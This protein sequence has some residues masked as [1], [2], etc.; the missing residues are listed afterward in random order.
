MRKT[1]FLKTNVKPWKPPISPFL[2]LSS[3]WVE[4]LLSGMRPVHFLFYVGEDIEKN[5]KINFPSPSRNRFIISAPLPPSN[6]CSSTIKLLLY[7][8]RSAPL[9]PSKCSSTII[10]GDPLPSSEVLLY[11]HQGHFSAIIKKPP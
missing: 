9:I 6:Y 10:K 4:S 11:N 5:H 8:Q 1:V 7:H 2:A 3:L